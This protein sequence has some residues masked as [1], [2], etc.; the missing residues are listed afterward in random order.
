MKEMACDWF[1]LSREDLARLLHRKSQY[2]RKLVS[3]MIGKHLA[4]TIPDM[5]RHPD[6]A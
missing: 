4:Y 6:Q 3:G 2:V 5:I 1:P